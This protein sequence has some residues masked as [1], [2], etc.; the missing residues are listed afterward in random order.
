MQA[1]RPVRNPGSGSVEC[2]LESA[3]DLAALLSA[4]QFRGKDEKDQ[5]VH[6]EASNRGLK[7]IAQSAGKDIMVLGW[8]FKEAFVEYQFAGSV[9]ELHLRLPVAPLISCL[10]VFSDRAA[11]VMKY[12]SGDLGELR[13]TLEENGDTTEC[14]VRTFAM[15]EAP[16]PLAAFFSAT[17]GVTMFRPIQAESW[18]QALSEFADLEAP[19]VAL[20]V[21]LSGG[22]GQCPAGVVLRAQTLMGDA[23]VKLGGLD[24]MV[25]APELAVSG[26]L[27]HR[28]LLTSVMGSCL[29]A[30]KDAKAVKV[31]FNRDGVMSNQ[32]ILR[33]RGQRDL[34]C[35]AVV[36]PI[37]DSAVGLGGAM[38]TG[39]SYTA[40]A[41]SQ[42]LGLPP[43]QGIVH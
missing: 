32:F 37:V 38:G 8:I 20:S 29:R 21:V 5:H 10:Q 4:L 34:L 40:A 19:D 42:N 24:E 41:A 39:P 1:P 9:D 18:H 12:P 16:T 22:S 25:V 15:E 11:M 2:R 28:Y 36:C 7:F 43:S 27:L 31:R 23:E 33:G 26:E 17:D 3:H 30:A 6:C 13:F 14:T 35:E